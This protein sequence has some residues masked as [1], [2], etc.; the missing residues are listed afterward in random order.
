LETDRKVK[1]RDQNFIT[2]RFLGGPKK[3]GGFTWI[4]GVPMFDVGDRDMLF[5]RKN[6][7]RKLPIFSQ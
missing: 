1:Q 5:V 7:M 6:G 3:N 2:L 4:P